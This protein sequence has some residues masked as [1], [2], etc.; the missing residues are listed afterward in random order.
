[1]KIKINKQPFSDSLSVLLYSDK[2]RKRYA[3]KPVNLIAKEIKEGT[4]IEPTFSIPSWEAHEFLKSMAELCEEMGIKTDKQLQEESK[5]KGVLEA[6]K[7]HLED[8]RKLVFKE[9]K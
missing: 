3:V 9:N 2:D 8:M 6:T 1:M 7:Y 4:S 5:N